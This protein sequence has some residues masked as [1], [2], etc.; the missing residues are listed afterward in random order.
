MVGSST[1]LANASLV[2]TVTTVVT[3]LPMFWALPT[4]ILTDRAA[5]AGLALINCTRN[6]SGYLS[7]TIIGEGVGKNPT[8]KPA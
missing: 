6:L 7:P 8:W 5:S 4:S 3:A 1:T 2:L